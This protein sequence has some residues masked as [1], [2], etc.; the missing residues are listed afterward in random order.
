MLIPSGSFFKMLKKKKK[1]TPFLKIHYTC[2]ER[3]QFSVTKEQLTY[4]RKRGIIIKENTASSCI[5]G[6]QK[7]RELFNYCH[8]RLSRSQYLCWASAEGQGVKYLYFAVL[9]TQ[10]VS[11]AEQSPSF[12]GGRVCPLGDTKADQAGLVHLLQSWAM[13]AGVA[14]L[15]AGVPGA[16]FL[17]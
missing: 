17:Q 8:G 10:L 5:W 12:K 1:F 14:C 11:T 2:L 4:T 16:V 13:Q 15:P 6:E 9:E 7:P 3:V